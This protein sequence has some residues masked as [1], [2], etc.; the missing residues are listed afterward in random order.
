MNIAN[1]GE[2]LKIVAK[3]CGCKEKE[4]KVTY[5]LIDDSHGLCADKRDIISAEVEAC[6]RL[7]KY[8]I[9]KTDEKAIRKE[10][11]ELRMALDLMP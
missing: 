10:V 5:S 11:A 3:T 6:E 9:D 1:M 7:L 2:P 8:T 4:R